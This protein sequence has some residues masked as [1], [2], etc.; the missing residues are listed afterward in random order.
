MDS[1]PYST[2]CS[3][4]PDFLSAVRSNLHVSSTELR[5]SVSTDASE[6]SDGRH[7]VW[8]CIK[9]VSSLH[10]YRPLSPAADRALRTL[11]EGLEQVCERLEGELGSFSLSECMHRSRECKLASVPTGSS[12]FRRRGLVV[13]VSRT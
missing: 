1:S 4:P 2:A 7:K 13:T 11:S 6:G 8:R 3:L 9:A 12:L 10:L 5:A